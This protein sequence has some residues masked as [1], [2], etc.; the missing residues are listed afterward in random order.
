MDLNI[1]LHSLRVAGLFV[2]KRREGWVI[3]LM[4]GM[5]WSKDGR[6]LL[7]PSNPS[8]Q[9][10]NK[11]EDCLFPLEEA[12]QKALTISSAEQNSQEEDAA[13]EKPNAEDEGDDGENEVE[14]T[15][16]C[17]ACKKESLDACRIALQLEFPLPIDNRLGDSLIGKA[18]FTGPFFLCKN[19]L[20]EFLH[21]YIDNHISQREKGLKE[22]LNFI[23]DLI[24]NDK[25]L[26]GVERDDI[27]RMLSTMSRV[28]YPLLVWT[29]L[30]ADGQLP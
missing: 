24:H 17:Q 12:I 6:W 25:P 11:R 26:I 13:T 18:S 22:D 21:Y 23:I 1:T 8:D 2:S 5:V 28:Y 4:P 19:C 10:G 27:Q 14:V 3:E 16:K 29:Q 20:L 7:E 9:D 15:R 30:K